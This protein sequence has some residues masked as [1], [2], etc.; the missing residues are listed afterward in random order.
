MKDLYYFGTGGTKGD[1]GACDGDKGRPSGE[2]SR[3]AWCVVRGRA[4]C[5]VNLRVRRVCGGGKG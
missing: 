5:V 2:G 1:G 3:R 4:S